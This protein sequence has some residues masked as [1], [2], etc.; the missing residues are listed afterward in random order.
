M[1]LAY[2]PGLKRKESTLIRKFRQLPIS[3][4]ILV[5]EGEN[6]NYDTIVAQAQLSGKP[7]SINASHELGCYPDDLER[8]LLKTEGDSIEKDEVIA[9]KKTI[10][11][12]LFGK[13]G[14]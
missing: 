3:G 11:D 10:F 1:A 5:K 14:A 8:Y 6:V 12:R 2:T 7:Y 4:D 13:Q 9:I